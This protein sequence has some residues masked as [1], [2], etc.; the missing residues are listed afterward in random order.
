MFL[1]GAGSRSAK[2]RAR[3]DRQVRR[4]AKRLAQDRFGFS[5]RRIS[6]WHRHSC[7]CWF[8]TAIILSFASVFAADN[9]ISAGNGIMYLGGPPNHAFL[10]PQPPPKEPTAI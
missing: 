7:L 6:M 10:I 1:A 3:L 9:K 4:R 5:M 2:P 8:S